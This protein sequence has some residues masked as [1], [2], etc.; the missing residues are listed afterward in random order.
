MRK[1]LLLLAITF[2][3]LLSSELG[4]VYGLDPNGDGFLA[5]RKKP[6]STQIG[7]LYNGDKVKILDRRGKWYKVKEVRSGKIGWSHSNWI[8]VRKSRNN[9]S[10]KKYRVFRIRSNDTLSVRSNAGVHNRK[11]G[12]LAYNAK[13]IKKIKCKNSP[14]GERWCKVSH[15][16]IITGWVSAKYITSRKSSTSNYAK[17]H[18]SSKSYN[19]SSEKSRNNNAE[20]GAAIAV[21]VIA[22]GLGKM[23]SGDDSSSTVNS[24]SSKTSQ[25]ERNFC[26][27]LKSQNA[28]EACLG[29]A[30]STNENARNVILGNCYSITGYNKDGMIQVCTQG[31]N[32][33]YSLKGSDTVHGCVSCDGSRR[34]LR[35]YAAG[36][37]INCY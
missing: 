4:T 16:S 13:G 1:I 20:L 30:Y 5:L 17:S 12:D 3:I 27:T 8:S 29:N 19:S 25:K 22:W 36:A 32:G 14:K 23:F 28:I 35:M 21:G 6:K 18:S 33:C 34:W 2:S 37:L 11:I 31:K 9:S 10:S 15:Y 26:F 7:K 24:S